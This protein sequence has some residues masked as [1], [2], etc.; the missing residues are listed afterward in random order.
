MTTRA[1]L[2]E[3]GWKSCF[4]P[5][6]QG[7]GSSAGCASRCLPAKGLRNTPSSEADES[8][9]DEILV[10]DPRHPLYGCSFRVVGRT[11]HRGGNFSPFYEVEYRDGVTLRVPV[12]ATE[13][14]APSAALTKLSMDSLRDLLNV[15]DCNDHEHGTRSSLDDAAAD[16][17][18]T[19]RRRY[20][21]GSGG[22]LS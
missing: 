7:V 21:R 14:L 4:I 1:S 13:P 12:T 19:D 22:G 9:P 6:L 2:W 11:S 16:P 15:V 18:T 10:R 3:T 17:A 8:F 5:P 20:R